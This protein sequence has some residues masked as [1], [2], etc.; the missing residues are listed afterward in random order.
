MV[1]IAI[2]LS[3]YYEMIAA[4]CAALFYIAYVIP[5]AC[6]LWM[7]GPGP[8][9]GPWTLGRWYPPLAVVC[10]LGCLGLLV[11]AVQPPNEIALWVLPAAGVGSAALWFGHFRLHFRDEVNRALQAL[12]LSAIPIRWRS[13]RWAAD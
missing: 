2:A 9:M 7:H 10:V 3:G 13:R 1:T 5:T 4:A 12:R 11:L 8:R 6:G